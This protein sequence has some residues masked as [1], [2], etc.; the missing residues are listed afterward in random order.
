MPRLF[1]FFSLIAL[2]GLLAAPAAA[3]D[4]AG[5]MPSGNLPFAFDLYQ[6]LRGDDGNLFVSPS[7]I[8][9]AFWLAWAGAEGE[10]AAQIGRA[11]F[12]AETIDDLIAAGMP[13][14]SGSQPSAPTDADQP[15]PL[16]LRSANALWAQ[17]DF[18][19]LPGYLDYAQRSGAP[20]QLVDYTVDPEAIREQ[21]NAWVEDQTEDR[22][23]DLIPQGMI[24]AL[25]RM[26]IANAVYFQANWE[27]AFEEALTQDGDFRLLDGATVSVPMM[28]MGRGRTL[29]AHAGDGYTAVALPYVGGTHEMVIIMP[30]DF[31]TFESEL[32]SERYADILA[33]LQPTL[34]MVTLPRFSFEYET[35]L[36]DALA[37]LGITDAFEPSLADFGRMYDQAAQ[38]E[39]LF[40]SAALHKA[41]VAVDEAGTE[42]A[43]ATA[44]I[45]ELTSALIDEPLAIRI[46][47]PFFFAIQDTLNTVLFAGRVVNPA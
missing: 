36:K 42:A 44:I 13:S 5:A 34:A 26:V 19:W 45:I 29:R 15:L 38:A 24:D 7:S 22:I 32:T 14:A 4:S 47:R 20:V 37:A 23:Q 6:A 46:D 12:G 11:M 40:V 33:G 43:A 18:P 16:T 2:L 25:T 8:Q 31:G 3:Q 1:S 27:F 39:N 9:E 35:E 10:T 17:Q 28:S 21:I 30:D 41:F